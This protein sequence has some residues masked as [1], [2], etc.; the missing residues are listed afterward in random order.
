MS[1]PK[2][3]S[4]GQV[5][6]INY[7][8]QNITVFAPLNPEVHYGDYLKISGKARSKVINGRNAISINA[9]I[10]I[11]NN[12]SIVAGK[13]LALANFFRQKIIKFYS[14]NLN[15]NEGG[16]LMGIVFGIKEGIPSNF[17]R[18]LKNAGVMHV[19]AASGMN[20]TMVGGFLSS[21]FL[22]FLRRQVALSFSIV[23]IIFYAVLAG[24]EPSIIRASIMG[25]LVFLA[26]ILGRQMWA[27]YSLLLTGFLMLFWN[28]SLVFDIGFQLS[29]LATCGLLFMK[30]MFKN[31]ILGSFQTTIF[32][33]IA[34][35]PILIA[36]FGTYSL[37]SIL[38]NSLVLWTV[39]LLMVIGGV[40]VII[41]LI[42][43]PVA[44]LFLY[45]SL[46]LLIYFESVIG[47]F[48]S[49]GGIVNMGG[50]SW[51][52]ISGYYLILVGIIYA[53]K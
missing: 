7:Q 52:V 19:I 33:Q 17:M 24:L 51:Q 26:A 45:F 14:S 13:S 44:R 31:P 23:G 18:D 4:R 34:T 38:V 49:L 32:A 50:L 47:F 8:N 43:E 42:F 22:L 12:S 11:E 35:T 27:T 20:V 39:P 37:W 25:S 3:T 30:S 16:L 2:V 9:N 10:W 6:S 5:F 29:F 28:P 21:V 48:S 41:S 15:P 1:E 36:N 46:P 53:R 40:S